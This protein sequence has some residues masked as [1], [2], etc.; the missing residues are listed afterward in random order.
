MS[1]PAHLVRHQVTPKRP[2]V[3]LCPSQGPKGGQ[4]GSAGCWRVSPGLQRA[5]ECVKEHSKRRASSV[6]Y[7]TR[8]EEVSI[9]LLQEGF[10]RSWGNSH[11]T[12]SLFLHFKVFSWVFGFLLVCFLFELGN[13]GYGFSRLLFGLICRGTA[14]TKCMQPG[15]KQMQGMSLFRSSTVTLKVLLKIIF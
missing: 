10:I 15:N 14:A 5:A 2:L 6:V 13:P 3:L 11:I 4:P 8:Y 7:F 12:K 9:I 1:S